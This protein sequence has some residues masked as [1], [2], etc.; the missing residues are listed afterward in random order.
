MSEAFPE[1]ILNLI[2]LVRFQH[3]PPLLPLRP[4]VEKIWI[5]ESSG[6]VQNVDSKLIVPTGRVRLLLPFKNSVTNVNARLTYVSKENSINLLGACDMPAFVDAA[7]K[8]P[9]GTIG[10]EFSHLGVYR[11]LKLRQSELTNKAYRLS[12]IVGKIARDL[13]EKICEV[14][15]PDKK[16]LLV[17][18]FLWKHFLK[19]PDE[20][21]DYCVSK[22]TSTHGRVTIRQLERE[23]GYSARWLN[24]KF[25]E[26]AG[27]SPKN[28]C[29]ISRFQ[30]IYGQLINNGKKPLVL[31]AFDGLYHDQSHFIKD[32]KR[33]TGLSPSQ[34]REGAADFGKVF[35]RD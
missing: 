20:I 24:I 2:V 13:E 1:T 34:F 25:H 18:H 9:S 12:E 26:R 28:L 19:D 15:S 33:F 27:M 35:Y 10:I 23:T 14:G 21:F 29:S 32:F 4:F 8:G 6:A 5:L 7:N 3:I 31:E 11:F 22:I 16:V 30:F 17:Q